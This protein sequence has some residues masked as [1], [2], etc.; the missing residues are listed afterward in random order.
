MGRHAMG[1]EHR[2]S[3]H[4]RPAGEPLE[5]TERGQFGTVL[6]V[7]WQVERL[8]EQVLAGQG[9]MQHLIGQVSA[10]LGQTDVPKTKCQHI[11]VTRKSV[12]RERH[13]RAS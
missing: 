2:G 5:H 13:T 11:S 7:D 3:A 6:R 1:P 4:E 10:H 9:G 8:F 12:C